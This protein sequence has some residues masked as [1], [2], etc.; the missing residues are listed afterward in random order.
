MIT[1]RAGPGQH[2]SGLCARGVVRVQIH[3]VVICTEGLRPAGFGNDVHLIT[4][5]HIQ[6]RPSTQTPVKTSR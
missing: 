2:T 1:C 6:A 4:L 3:V 5:V